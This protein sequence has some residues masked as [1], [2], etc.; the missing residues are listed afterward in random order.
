M[1]AH[2]TVVKGGLAFLSRG[3]KSDESVKSRQCLLVWPQL[4]EF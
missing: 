3:W 4:R 2:K 1:E